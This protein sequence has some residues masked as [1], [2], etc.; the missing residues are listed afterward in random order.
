M[1]QCTSLTLIGCHASE[2]AT[3]AYADIA[4]V[5]RTYCLKDRIA[6]DVEEP[7]ARV[8]LNIFV[9]NDD[10][11]LRNHSF[12]YDRQAKGWRLSPLYDVVSK[13]RLSQS[14]R[15]H[16]DIGQRSPSAGSDPPY[17]VCRS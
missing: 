3:K 4:R 2:S 8:V 10:D 13:A 1:G 5:I 11:H 12:R 9:P 7:Y 6:A 17:L 16:L 15:L 14:R